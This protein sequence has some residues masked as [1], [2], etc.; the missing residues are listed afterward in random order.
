MVFLLYINDIGVH[1]NHST[2]RLFADDC[3]LYK[4]LSN[5]DDADRLQDDLDELQEWTDSWQMNIN[6][7]K[8]YLISMHSKRDPALNKYR[9]NGE[10]IVKT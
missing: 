9:L 10:E 1:L 5:Q 8:C 7:T 3:L 6:A 2:I 4:T